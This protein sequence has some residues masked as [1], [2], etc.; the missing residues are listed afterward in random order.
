MLLQG[1][2]IKSNMHDQPQDKEVNFENNGAGRQEVPRP[3]V[4]GKE[5]LNRTV[6]ADIGNLMEDTIPIQQ[7]LLKTHNGTCKPF[8]TKQMTANPSEHPEN[9]V[10]T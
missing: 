2:L 6:M 9:K 10:C 5:K 7:N 4:M 8:R 3:R 1:L